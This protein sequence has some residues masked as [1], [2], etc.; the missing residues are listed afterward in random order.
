MNCIASLD[1]SRNDIGLSI[2]LDPAVKCPTLKQ[3][4]LSYNQLSSVP[5]N[6]TD[7][8]EKLEQLIL[9]G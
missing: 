3:L 4:N 2:V 6:L 5:E 7:V 1:A 9:E 8:V